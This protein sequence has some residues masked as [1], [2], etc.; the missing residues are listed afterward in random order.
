[1]G[2]EPQRVDG[3][4]VLLRLLRLRPLQAATEHTPTHDGGG[5]G[6]TTV[7]CTLRTVER[8]IASSVTAAGAHGIQH[9]R[10]ALHGR[11][12]SGEH[13]LN[14]RIQRVEI[15]CFDIKRRVKITRARL[16][17]AGDRRRQRRQLVQRAAFAN[18]CALCGRV[19]VSAI[20]NHC[21]LAIST[22]HRHWICARTRTRTG[23]AAA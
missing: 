16:G 17:I 10:D 8:I 14:G 23:T 20:G 5:I 2:Q 11:I 3:A 1:M 9:S 6:I 12:D 18:Q 13:A 22:H 19:Q 7:Y 15:D 4:P 21:V